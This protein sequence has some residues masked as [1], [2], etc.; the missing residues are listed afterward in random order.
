MVRYD[1]FPAL[2][3]LGIVK[4]ELF[5]V[6]CVVKTPGSLKTPHLIV[7]LGNFPL[8]H[9]AIWMRDLN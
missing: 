7:K 1:F 3:G 8:R 6:I 9:F 4:I 2:T 5:V